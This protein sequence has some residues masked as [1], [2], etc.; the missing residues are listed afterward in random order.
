MGDVV[1]TTDRL[2]LRR[3][4]EGDIDL[5]MQHLNT[6]PVM[7]RLGGVK[8]RAQIAD[9][10]AKAQ[11]CFDTDGFGFMM[12]FE[13]DTG[14]LVGHCGLKRVDNPLAPNTGDHEIGWLIREDRWRMGYAEEAVRAIIEWGFGTH[15]APHLVALTS[16]AN[17]GS[18]RLMEKLGM[19]RRPDLDFSDSG[20]PGPDDPTIQYALTKEQWEKT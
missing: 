15:G 12:V 17:T 3:I 9:K 13:R 8:S 6:P 14:E 20:F 18:W 4:G 11:A 16:K 5:Q 7:A 1:L 2:E 10:H 19:V